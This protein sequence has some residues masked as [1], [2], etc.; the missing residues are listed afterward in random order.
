MICQNVSRGASEARKGPSKVSQGV[1]QN[2]Q[3]YVTVLTQGYDKELDAHMDNDAHCLWIGV[4]HAVEANNR[5]AARS[6]I[7]TG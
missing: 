6:T 7:K 5:V 1:W 2:M 4:R 3:W